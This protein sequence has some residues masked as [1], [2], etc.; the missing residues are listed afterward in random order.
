MKSFKKIVFSIILVFTILVVFPVSASAKSDPSSRV[1]D[2]DG[3]L[4]TTEELYVYDAIAEAESLT[5]IIFLV[6]V[7]DSAY[8]IPS[9]E[10]TVRSFGYSPNYDDVVLLIIECH[11]S[12]V[13][14]YEMFT[15][16]HAHTL[17]TNKAVDRILDSSSV[18]NNIKSGNLADGAVA[19]VSKTANE[20]DKEISSGGGFDVEEIAIRI[21]IALAAGII[22][23]VIVIVVYKTKL[24]S[25]I[26]P[27][28]QFT[29]LRLTER[30]DRYIGKTVTRT[31]ISSSNSSSGS[32]GS[33]G[34]SRGKR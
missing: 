33:S 17:I 27:L 6:A 26:Y 15:Y 2:R 9:G 5:D 4:S 13:Y 3:N 34:G 12:G 16:G 11:P 25:P 32:S 7:Y 22:A 14:Y 28:S 10:E 23:V 1:M 21:G 19:F 18:Y 31:K 8:G 20:L 30:D 24:K 29:D